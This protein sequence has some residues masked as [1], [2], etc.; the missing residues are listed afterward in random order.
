MNPYIDDIIIHYLEMRVA[1][2]HVDTNYL[3]MRNDWSLD[4]SNNLVCSGFQRHVSVLVIRNNARIYKYF[5][6]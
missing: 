2:Y 1:N 6:I 5:A 3:K 4:C